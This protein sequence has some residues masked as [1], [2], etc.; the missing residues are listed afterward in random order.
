MKTRVCQAMGEADAVTALPVGSIVLPVSMCSHGRYDYEIQRA[1]RAHHVVAIDRH[2][3]HIV[4]DIVPERCLACR[5]INSADDGIVIIVLS[6]SGHMHAFASYLGR[7]V[8]EWF[9]P[10]DAS[11]CHHQGSA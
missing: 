11:R 1:D 8:L 4:I 6:A 7:R 3:L 10:I 2:A 9:A 5:D